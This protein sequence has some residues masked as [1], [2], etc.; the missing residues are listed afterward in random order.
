[1]LPM[2]AQEIVKVKVALGLE[3]ETGC[4]E[5]GAVEH[6][7]KSGSRVHLAA[8]QPGRKPPPF[9]VVRR[10]S[11]DPETNLLVGGELQHSPKCAEAQVGAPLGM[12]V[13]W[14]GVRVISH[15]PLRCGYPG[16]VLGQPRERIVRKT[17]GADD[18]SVYGN[19]I[20]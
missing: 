10:Y 5:V 3:L 13:P 15:A 8:W 2:R 6:H 11:R 18:E 7:L 9:A 17:I 20:R 4:V 14:S 16:E 1:M 12:L 19:Q